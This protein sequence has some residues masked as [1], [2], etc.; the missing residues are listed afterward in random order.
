MPSRST[1]SWSKVCSSLR[2]SGRVTRITWSASRFTELTVTP[3]TTVTQA[4]LRVFRE[5]AT[6]RVPGAL[7]R[8]GA[9]LGRDL[10]EFSQANPHGFPCCG[11]LPVPHAITPRQTCH[12]WIE[13]RDD[14]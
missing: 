3:N 5:P 8:F 4:L 7:L 6:Q 10:V 12:T 2:F 11:D 13:K 1:W 9:P 14:A